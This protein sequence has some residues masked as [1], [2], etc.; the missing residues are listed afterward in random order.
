MSPKL[1]FV[2]GDEGELQGRVVEQSSRRCREPHGED[3]TRQ[4]KFFR[5]LEVLEDKHDSKTGSTQQMEDDTCVR[6]HLFESSVE[7]G[8][9]RSCSVEQS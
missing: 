5:L 1:V 4:G 3:R 7:E 2:I 8:I 6:V 9:G